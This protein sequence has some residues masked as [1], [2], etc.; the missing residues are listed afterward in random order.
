M[1]TYNIKGKAIGVKEPL[2]FKGA[3]VKSNYKTHTAK[4]YDE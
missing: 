1:K 2:Y 4:V 3:M